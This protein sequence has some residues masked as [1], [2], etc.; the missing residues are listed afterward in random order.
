MN[1][2]VHVDL[3]V[4]TRHSRH[5]SE[6]LLQRIGASESY[7][8]VETVYKM[9]KTQGNAFVTITDH[10]T[11]DGAV[12]LCRM[13]PEDCF[14]STEATA[15]FPEDG[16]KVHILCYGITPAQFAAIQ[17]ARENIYNLRDYL[18]QAGIAC[19][20]AHAIFS[21]NG[22][23]TVEHVEKLLVMFDVF[24]GM[25][26]TRGFESNDIWRRVL[27]N[28]TRED[29][30]RLS[31]KHGID[32]WS[33]DSWIKGVTG[34]SDDHAG[35]FAGHTWT[36]AKASTK[37]EFL[38]ALRLRRTV[39]GGRCGDYKS[40]AYAVYKIAHEHMREKKFT[41]TGVA[42][43]LASILFSE[44]GPK[45]RERFLIRK[46]GFR[47]SR[48]DQILSQFLTRLDQISR[49]ADTH[50]ADWQISE[51]Y[52][53]LGMLLDDFAASIADGVSTGMRGGN[54]QGILQY[55]SSAI[56]AMVF[57][58]PFV[59]TLHVLN[60]CRGLNERLA[61]D[62][63]VRPAG[64]VRRTLWF[65]DTFADI[66]A[67]SVT[68]QTLS[69]IAHREGL[70]LK[71]VCCP[72]KAEMNHPAAKRMMRLESVFE[73][74]PEFDKA[75]TGRLPSLLSSLDAIAKAAADKIV[76]ST[77]GPVGIVGLIAAR[78]LGV[79]CTGVFHTDFAKQAEEAIGD[80]QVVGVVNRYIM[81]F[82][83][84]MD[85]VLVPSRDYIARLSDQGL[86]RSRMA[87]FRR[88]L[89]ASYRH[90]NDRLL[91]ETRGRWF[92]EGAP[93]IVYAGRLG[94]EKNLGLLVE[95]FTRLRGEG[96][97]VRLV[98]AGDGAERQ[99]LE[100]TLS[101]HSRDVSFTGR[102]GIEEVKCLYR[103]SDLLLFPSTTDTFGMTVLEA[104]TMGL[105]AIVTR[106]GGPQ[107]IIVDGQTGY[108]VEA[109]DVE[110]W[111]SLSRAL[112]KTRLV[113]PGRYAKWRE[114]IEGVFA[115]RRYTWA[116]LIDEIIEAAPAQT[117]PAVA[118]AEPVAPAI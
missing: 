50:G 18:R 80:E 54:G 56:P 55:F 17:Q 87:L 44:Y 8:P 98:V 81:W 60:K 38:E 92:R 66:N 113:D 10:N 57:A 11:I 33:E 41:S 48:R 6:W 106:A 65:T 73:Y 7:T 15:Y 117:A 29:I 116:S 34:G 27:G 89:D 62:F 111:V 105:P 43:L 77:P 20:V 108:A 78:L 94:R 76:I 9:A 30:R 86:D 51:A 1:E 64:D 102:L 88:G 21:V 99:N 24:E 83:G 26:G 74:T 46:L 84:A 45:L 91:E 100:R 49:D 69:G 25:N 61:A 79:P 67:V 63:R 3:H 16:C 90:V 52:M 97:P 31:A 5:P 104:Q 59:S 40:L 35:L 103:L 39:P 42:G 2:T 22:R 114:K 12:E 72:A 32:P 118:V 112:I 82:Y 23:L 115:Q 71:F 75:H 47:R 101:G 37:E 93:T 36:H 110:Q 19:S 68:V 107:E 85:T 96:M 109:D 28:V 13:H 70:P 53:A 4:H 14:I 58:A 95:V